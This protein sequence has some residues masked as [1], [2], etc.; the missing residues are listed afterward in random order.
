MA[1]KC[2]EI[3]FGEFIPSCP[4]SRLLQR[5]LQGL[6][7]QVLGLVVVAEEAVGRDKPVEP[8]S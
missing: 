3:V 1:G 7:Q 6:G 4:Q 8:A 5:Q 2:F